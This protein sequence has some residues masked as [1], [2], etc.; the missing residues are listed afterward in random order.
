[1][2]LEYF[3]YFV[4]FLCG[5]VFIVL[6]RDIWI[7]FNSNITSTG[8]KFAYSEKKAKIIHV[9]T[10][11]PLPAFKQKGLFY[12]ENEFR[13][14]TFEVEDIF[15]TS[16]LEE[17]KNTS[18]YNVKTL[19]SVVFGRCYSLYNQQEIPVFELGNLIKFRRDNDINLYIHT[20]GKK[21]S[22]LVRCS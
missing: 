11:C 5:F 22:V 21:C 8:I 10:V 4:N 16:F 12:L 20:P 13:A 2:Q 1:M 14:N 19:T 15:T 7:K 18:K 9:I 6:T 3:K 17:L